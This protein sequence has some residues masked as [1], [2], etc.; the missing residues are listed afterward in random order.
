MR[1]VYNI[2]NIQKVIDEIVDKFETV[3]LIEFIDTR[4]LFRVPKGDKTI[5]FFFGYLEELKTRCNIQE[6]SASET[7]LE[8]IFNSFAWEDE[9]TVKQ[10]RFGKKEKTQSQNLESIQDKNDEE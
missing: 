10:R 4:F 5:G 6:Y 3:E 1:W 8:Q 2:N 9:Q 7:T